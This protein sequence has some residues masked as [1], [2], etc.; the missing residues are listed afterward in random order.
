MTQPYRILVLGHKGMLGNAVVK[1]FQSIN[2]SYKVVTTETRW[3]EADFV[4]FLQKKEY[5]V[6]V[7]CIGG[8]PQ[9]GVKEH[10]LFF[11]N[12]ELPL[13]LDSLG[14]KVILPS[15]DCEFS[16]SIPNNSFYTKTDTR[17]A[18][19]VYGKSKA[20]ASFYLEN[21]AL[22]TKIIRTSILGHELY[23]NVSL[24]DWFLSNEGGEVFGF[25]DR[26]WNGITTL[27]WAKECEYIIH[28]FE[29]VPPLTQLGT[30]DCNSKYD[31]LNII[32]DVYLKDIIIHKKES[33]KHENKCL[34]SDKMLPSIREQLE[35][36][37]LFYE[38]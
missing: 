18:V 29:E 13:F 38:K 35:D 7:N 5:D 14:K 8:I 24:L 3:G 19:D 10:D 32:K 25:T 12:K 17:D 37:K 31:L 4:T 27:Q 2:K 20:E 28:H 23:S 36:L 26:F 1:Y 15:T 30:K 33:G 9:K 11:L 21:N 16:G 6:I 22:H 34:L